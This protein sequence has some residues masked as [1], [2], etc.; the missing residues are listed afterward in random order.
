MP[1]HPESTAAG[2]RWR[3]G[4]ALGRVG[5]AGIAA[6]LVASGCVT[7]AEHRK[8]ERQ[9]IDLQRRSQA[10][11]VARER[12]ANVSAEMDQI[13]NELR[14]LQGRIEVA[15]KTAADALEQARKAREQSVSPGARPVAET[16]DAAPEVQASASPR[17]S[18]ASVEP[19]ASDPEPDSE[20]VAAYRESYALWR[21]GEYGECIDRFRIFLQNYPASAYADDAGFWMA[22]CHFKQGDYKNAVLRFDDVVRNYPSGN[23]APDA[24]YRQGESLMKL[25][26]EF[27]EAA[28]RAFERVLKEY[29]DSARAEEAK[30]QLQVRGAG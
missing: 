16:A 30:R 1:I 11:A 29:P 14:R 23:K 4:R 21:G 6:A 17:P 2:P 3:T 19:K 18:P 28:R 5:L 27:H 8:L 22:D 7:V 12:I 25:G 26:P 13:R 10:G 24:L 15:D 20:E 9:V